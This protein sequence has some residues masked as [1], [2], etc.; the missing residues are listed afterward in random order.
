[1]NFLARLAFQW[2]GPAIR[3]MSLRRARLQAHGAA[4]HGRRWAY[5]LVTMSPSF[6]ES[7]NCSK[8]A[9]QK[10]SNFRIV[11]NVQFESFQIFELFEMR[12]LKSL[13]SPAFRT[14]WIFIF[15]E[16]SI[17]IYV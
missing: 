16:F 10:Y 2:P 13:N 14:L 17:Q 1:M 7:S 12:N 15:I 3:P 6:F 5:K 11:R 4:T 9:I 8:C